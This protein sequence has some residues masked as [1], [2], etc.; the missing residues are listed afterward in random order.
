M[1]VKIRIKRNKIHLDIYVNGKRHWESLGLTVPADRQQAREIMKLAEVCRSK[2][3][4]QITSG[5]W[6]LIDPVKSKLTLKAYMSTIGADRSNKDPVNRAIKYIDNDIALNAI[7]SKWLE[8][9]Q[10]HLLKDT[11]L[12][13]NTAA[14]YMSAI[15]YALNKAVRD[16]LI[17]RNPVK[18]IKKIKK[19]ETDKVFLETA[20]IQRLAKTPIG[21]ELG[22]EIKRVF[23][24]ACFTGLRISDIKALTW[25]DINRSPL[26]IIKRQKKTGL[27]VYIPLH[28]TA[29]ELINDKALHRHTELLFK[30][31][32][33]DCYEELNKWSKNA[34]IEKHIGWHTARHT[35][36][37]LSLESG[38]DIYTV[39]KL[40]GHTDLKTT[41]VY[42]KATDKMKREAVNGLPLIKIKENNA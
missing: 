6:G 3:E 37:V 5:E 32:N 42:A 36:A 22:Q 27:K 10:T 33:T 8:D 39:S 38:A 31:F 25:G 24:F 12:S 40:L 13:R 26:Q 17:I 28:V 14:F 19:I 20:E 4:A 7:N 2:R 30:P 35:F 34:G 1:G 9:F 23:L 18:S 41:Q 29:W 11:K 16:N 15:Q 21:G